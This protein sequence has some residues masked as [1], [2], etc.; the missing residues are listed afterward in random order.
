MKNPIYY[1]IYQRGNERKQGCRDYVASHNRINQRAAAEADKKK[2]KCVEAGARG[3]NIPQCAC[4]QTEKH[5]PYVPFI[6]CNAHHAGNK[7]Q[8]PDTEKLR[9]QTVTVLQY[10]QQQ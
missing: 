2:K 10:G 4:K 5:S 1:I 6:H 9:K 7:Q 3:E 8:S